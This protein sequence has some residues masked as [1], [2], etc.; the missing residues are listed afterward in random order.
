MGGMS[1]C[2]NFRL[3][4]IINHRR[5]PKDGCIK[6]EIFFPF[7]GTFHVLEFKCGLTSTLLLQLEESVL[8]LGRRAVLNGRRGTCWEGQGGGTQLF[9]H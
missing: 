4:C 8:L 9:C 3:E 7:L 1:Q 6:N 2:E 5:Y